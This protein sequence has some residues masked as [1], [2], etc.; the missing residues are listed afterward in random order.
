MYEIR[1]QY[2]FTTIELVLVIIIIG[3]L[4]VTIIPKMQST[5]GYEEIT[6]QDEIGRAH[7]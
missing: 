5:G 2:G 1:N 6:Y 4:A 7:V 3:I